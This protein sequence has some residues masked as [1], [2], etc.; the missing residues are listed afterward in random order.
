MHITQHAHELLARIL[1]VSGRAEAATR[2][3][4]SVMKDGDAGVPGDCHVPTAAWG[5]KKPKKKKPAKGVK[6][7]TVT[8]QSDPQE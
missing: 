1:K 5:G 6:I 2:S 7:K 8:L 3:L 4:E